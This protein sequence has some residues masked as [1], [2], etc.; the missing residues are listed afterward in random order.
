MTNAPTP[1]GDD[2]NVSTL[3]HEAV[4]TLSQGFAILG[5]DFR[6]VY[7]N[8]RAWRHHGNAYRMF[9]QGFGLLDAVV[10]SMRRARPDL[11]EDTCRELSQKLVARLEAGK[12][13]DLFTD[14]ARVGRTLLT[15]L[16]NGLSL[17]TSMDITEL[18]VA[19]LDAEAATRARSEFLASMSHE[20]RTPMNGIMGM[21]L[22]LLKSTL[23]AEQRRYANAVESSAGA[24]LGTINDILDI[25]KLEARSVDLESVEFSLEEIVEDV[26]DLLAPRAAERDLELRVSFDENARQI[27]RGDPTRIRQIILNL[28]TNGIK[29]TNHGGVSVSVESNKLESDRMALRLEVSDTGIGVNDETRSRLFRN[30]AQEDGSITRR[31]GGTGLG[32]SICRELVELMRGTIGVRENEGGGSIFRVDIELPSVPAGRPRSVAKTRALE[33]SHILVVDDAELDR[34]TFRRHLE[35]EGAIIEEAADAAA[36]LE[37]LHRAQTRGE[38]FDMVLLDFMMPAVAGDRVALGIRADLSL[39]QPIIVLATS[40]DAPEC[41]DLVRDGVI[42]ACLTKPIRQSALTKCLSRLHREPLLDT[43]RPPSGTPGTTW[44]R[45]RILLVEDND[46]NALLT[47][48]LL[49]EEGY[50]VVLASNGEIGVEA[51]ANGLFDLILM[52]VQMPVMDGIQATRLIRSFSSGASIP[53]IAMTASAMTGHRDACIAAGMNGYISKPISQ[54][55]LLLVVARAI[56]PLPAAEIVVPPNP[57]EQ[58]PYADLESARLDQLASSVP[59]GELR[60]LVSAFGLSLEQNLEQLAWDTDAAEMEAAQWRAHD[61][62]NMSGNFGALR[63]QHLAGL[64]ERACSTRDAELVPGLL[65]EIQRSWTVARRLLNERFPGTLAG[66]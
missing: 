3:I 62:E 34:T 9:E 5:P 22:L 59:P 1:P 11:D 35:A 24:L 21:N 20:I 10:G 31:T 14:D 66:D 33:S 30:F 54:E 58:S 57:R 40:V 13:T 50:T 43:V 29:F 17:V 60:D 64:L 27:L 12:P 19:Q 56:Q 41:R 46:I 8:A 18:R 4:N 38:P 61:L 37:A 55:T 52:D 48:T 63:V 51:A 65:S 26:L 44:E 28:V 6:V 49:A 47:K 16:S 53:I 25:S 42:D 32:L 15:K 36:C 39:R 2:S 45:G 7:A 23:T